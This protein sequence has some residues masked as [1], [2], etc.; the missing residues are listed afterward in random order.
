MELLIY[1]ELVVCLFN[2]ADG[3]IQVNLIKKM[4]VMKGE[5]NHISSMLLLLLWLL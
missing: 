3:Y 5:K 4:L 2:Y 1:H